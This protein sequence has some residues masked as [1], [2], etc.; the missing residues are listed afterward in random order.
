MP[1]PGR[2]RNYSTG[3]GEAL[4]APVAARRYALL[5]QRREG[6]EL[7]LHPEGRG[8]G[9]LASDSANSPR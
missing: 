5:A 4:Y 3:D 6:G 8:D 2:L 1:A 7:P 9:V